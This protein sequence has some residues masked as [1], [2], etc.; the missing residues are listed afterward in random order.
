[1]QY[2]EQA[3]AYR[4]SANELYDMLPGQPRTGLP[5]SDPVY[6]L[7]HHAA[8]LAL[9]AC[10]QADGVPNRKGTHKIAALFAKCRRR[11]LL[12]AGDQHHEMHN[13]LVFLGGKSFG[14][15]YRYAGPNGPRSSLGMGS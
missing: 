13:L 5:L 7:Y 2:F 11:G 6:F 9:R 14:N 12:G 8:E 15:E 4:S 10:L 3:L 1:M